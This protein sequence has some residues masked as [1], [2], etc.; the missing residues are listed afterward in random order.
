MHCIAQA[1]LN[2]QKKEFPLYYLY[3]TV[4]PSSK[5]KFFTFLRIDIKI[6]LRNVVFPFSNAMENGSCSISVGDL[7]AYEYKLNSCF[8]YY[9]ISK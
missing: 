6:R 1:P 8:L 9:K 2:P 4:Y 5:N 3:T 7:C